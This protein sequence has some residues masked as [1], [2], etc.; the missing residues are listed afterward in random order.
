MTD[1]IAIGVA[2]A[3]DWDALYRCLASAFNE[4][5]DAAESATE[6]MLFEPERTLIARREGEIVGTAAILTRRLSV[7]GAVIP[8]AHVTSV[9]VAATARRQGV[10]RRFMHRQFADARSAGEPIAVLWASEAR[11]YQRFGYGLAATKLALRVD[12]KD[13]QVVAPVAGRLREAKPADVRET[14]AKIYGDVYVNRPGWSEREPRHWEYYLADI[15]AWRKG[16]TVLRAV[17]HEGDHGPDG[18]ALW[19]TTSEWSVTGPNGE[20]K[21]VEVVATTPTAYA[22]LWRFLLTMDLTRTATYRVAGVDEPLLY[23]V[24]EPRRLG[25]TFG[26]A[27]WLRI[28]DVPAAL[29]A[30]RYATPI[31]HVIEV[32][33]ELI[34]ANS[35]RWRLVGSRQSATCTPTT[36][37]ADLAVDVRALGAAYL[38]GTRLSS[39]AA[40][41][42]VR[43]LTPGTLATANAA[44][45]W[46]VPASGLEVF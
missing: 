7:P 6:R 41:G 19:R 17:I 30:R 45:S 5:V 15:E 4:N 43:E 38:G 1:D 25:A 35:G 14:L 24:D 2:S 40:A 34:P 46:D 8:A 21:V 11:I 44:F 26:D 31:D 28:V 32:V 39:L 33:D 10:L 37:A 42:L 20:V 23:L 9:S 18:Y 29:A 27:L 13:L 12:T 3:D 16:A 22:S 36:D